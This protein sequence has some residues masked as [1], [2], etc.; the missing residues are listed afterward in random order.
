MRPPP[1]PIRKAHWVLYFIPWNLLVGLL[2]LRK[3]FTW[4]NILAAVVIPISV[5]LALFW[6][7]KPGCFQ[8][9]KRPLEDPRRLVTYKTQ[10][11]KYWTFVFLCFFAYLSMTLLA[12]LSAWR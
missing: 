8:D 12:T 6:V 4:G 11:G 7:L 2:L 5:L 10:P 9:P 3:P 1:L